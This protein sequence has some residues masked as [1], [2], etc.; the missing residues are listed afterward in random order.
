MQGNARDY[1][2]W[3]PPT[4]TTPSTSTT[5]TCTGRAAAAATTTSGSRASLPSAATSSRTSC[6]SSAR[7]TR[8]IPGP[9]ATGS[10]SATTRCPA[11]V[12]RPV[13]IRSINKNLGFNGQIKMTAAPMKGLRVSAS[14]VDNWS[15]YRGA[16]PSIL[17]SQ[18]QSYAWGWRATTIPIGRAA[19]LAD[20]SASN[21]FLV[22]LRGGYHLT[23]T[24]QP[25]DHEQVHDVRIRHS[26]TTCSRRDPFYVANPTLLHIAGAGQTTAAPGRSR[27]TTRSRSTPATSTCP[28]SPAWPASMPLRP[29]SRSSATRK[30]SSTVLSA[31]W[32]TSAG[33]RTARPSSPT[34]PRRPAAPTAIYDI[35]GQLAPA[36]RLRLGHL[37]EHLR[38]LPPGFLDDRRQADHQRRPPDGERV[39][40]DVQSRRSARVREA[41]RVRLR[42]QAG[43]PLRRR[44]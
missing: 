5:T 20:Y 41:H 11:P 27:T 10:S 35:R 1:F 9:G 32:S 37:P 43:P 38:H 28:I 29:A 26:R 18:H 17:G 34:A 25:A 3:D 7:S 16:I 21:N 36:L 22:S 15:N 14:F 30:T 6:G 12:Q 44:L 19:F 23:D 13:T 4:A 31:R 42:R 8:S 33:T 2:R 40:P 39:H 24:E